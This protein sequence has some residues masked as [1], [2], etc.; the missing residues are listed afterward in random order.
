MKTT[1]FSLATFGH[2]AQAN[3]DLMHTCTPWEPAPETLIRFGQKSS[4]NHFYQIFGKKCKKYVEFRTFLA[5]SRFFW[6]ILTNLSDFLAKFRI[7]KFLFI[8]YLYFQTTE[9]KYGILHDF[10]QR[11]T[12]DKI[13]F[14][15]TKSLGS[16]YRH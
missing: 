15:F 7:L 12:L 2:L 6:E 4:K 11:A 1:L 5:V 8:R 16:N 10:N 3:K 14:H 9:C 13:S